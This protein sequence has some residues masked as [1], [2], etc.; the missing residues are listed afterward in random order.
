MSVQFVDTYYLLA[1]VNA[2]DKDHEKAVRH[3]QGHVGSLLTTTWVLV[4]LADALCVVGSR[5]GAARF[6]RGFTTQPAA[7]KGVAGMPQGDLPTEAFS[8]VFVLSAGLG[9]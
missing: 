2:R 9:Q 4:E 3:S 7:Q 6:I 5:E 8:R 1:L